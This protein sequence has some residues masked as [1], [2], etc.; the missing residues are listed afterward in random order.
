MIFGNKRYVAEIKV[1]VDNDVAV[2]VTAVVAVV[3]AVVVAANTVAATTYIW[4]V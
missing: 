1:A 2:D 4:P 3:V